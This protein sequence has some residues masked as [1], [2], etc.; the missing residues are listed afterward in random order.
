MKIFR[1]VQHSEWAGSGK[2][3]VEQEFDGDEVRY[4]CACFA[5]V[6]DSVATNGDADPFL[7]LFVRFMDDDN[8]EIGGLSTAGHDR[9]LNEMR[10]VG[11][12]QHVG[13]VALTETSE[14]VG[15]RVFPEWSFRALQQS[16][17]FI[18]EAGVWVDGFADSRHPGSIGDLKIH[19]TMLEGSSSEWVHS[20]VR[21]G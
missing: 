1:V 15:A 3:V 2:G 4:F 9:G 5:R 21:C 11:S 13:Q 14:F 10:G 6:I 12:L 17:V 16:F 8:F 7:D 20:D 19:N 18:I